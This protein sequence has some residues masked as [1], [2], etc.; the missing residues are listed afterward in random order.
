MGLRLCTTDLSHSFP[1]L[2]FNHSLAYN[3]LHQSFWISRG[4]R[5]YKL[6][7][8]PILTSFCQL[9]KLLLFYG[10]SRLRFYHNMV[11]VVVGLINIFIVLESV[12]SKPLLSEKS[13]LVLQQDKMVSS[14]RSR[15]KVWCTVQCALQ[16]RWSWVH[17]RR[18]RADCQVPT[19]QCG[20]PE[21]LHSA[22]SVGHYGNF[23][24]LV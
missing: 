21:K 9:W 6:Y 3:P 15:N 1:C 24:F 22:L 17:M 18:G 20:R 23:T 5:F 10:F 11:K 13:E 8:L 2:Q 16:R 19:A 12:H 4:R 14:I 7:H